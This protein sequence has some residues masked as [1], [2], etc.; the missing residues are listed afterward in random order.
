MKLVTFS[1]L[2]SFFNIHSVDLFHF[3]E[4][5]HEE[6]ATIFTSLLCAF[7]I[8]GNK[9]VI[10]SIF[11]TKK[12]FNNNYYFFVLHFAIC[13]TLAIQSTFIVWILLS[14]FILKELAYMVLFLGFLF[15][16]I[17]AV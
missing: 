11:K 5:D 13:D 1:Q 14:I 16:A 2:Y 17:G 8:I 10:I 3:S 4:I 12:L 7:G 15:Q 9:L 6:V